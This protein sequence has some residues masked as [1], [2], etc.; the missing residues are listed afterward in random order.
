M[1]V[2]K[3]IPE[4]DLNAFARIVANAYPDSGLATEEERQTFVQR[5][6]ESQQNDDTDQTS[7]GC[8]RDDALVGGMRLLDFNANILGTKC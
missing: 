2:I 8:S 3:L 5:L 4:S 6:T 1:S 7:T